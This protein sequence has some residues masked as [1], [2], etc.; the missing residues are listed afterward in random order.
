MNVKSSKAEI[1]ISLSLLGHHTWN[2]ACHVLEIRWISLYLGLFLTLLLLILLVSTHF[3]ASFSVPGFPLVSL[4][5]FSSLFCKFYFANTARTPLFHL[6]TFIEIIII[7]RRKQGIE[8]LDQEQITCSRNW[9][10]NARNWGKE[11]NITHLQGIHDLK[12]LYTIK[13]KL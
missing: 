6:W 2:S 8:Y 13:S 7:I 3:L 5:S 12:E 10:Q 11:I 1:F 4:H 9:V